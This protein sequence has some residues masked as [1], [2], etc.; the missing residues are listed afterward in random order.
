[1]ELLLFLSAMLGG[2]TGLIA[3]DRPIEA[4]Q[5][6]Q[7]AIAAVAAAELGIGH[8]EQASVTAVPPILPVGSVATRP[9]AN[10]VTQ[11]P[12]GRAAVDERR[13]E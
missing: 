11:P 6:E 5:M 10:P 3:G 4:R 8:S 7:V 13:L 1:L 12:H 9:S 2:L